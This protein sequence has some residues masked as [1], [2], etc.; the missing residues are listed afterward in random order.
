MAEYKTTENDLTEGEKNLRDFLQKGAAVK[1]LIDKYI[2]KN[3]KSVTSEFCKKQYY[4][5]MKLIHEK[6]CLVRLAIESEVNP[7]KMS[8]FC[9]RA[10]DFDDTSLEEPGDFLEVLKITMADRLPKQIMEEAYDEYTTESYYNG[11]MEFLWPDGTWRR[12]ENIEYYPCKI[13]R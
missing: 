12:E 7:R 11:T 8:T 4:L 5:R 10:Y 6:H 13:S 3:E 1:Q 9:L 2:V